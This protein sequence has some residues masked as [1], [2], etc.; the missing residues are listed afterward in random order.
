MGQDDAGCWKKLGLGEEIDIKY[1]DTFTEIEGGETF[2]ECCSSE[3]SQ[4]IIEGFWKTKFGT[5]LCHDRGTSTSPD[6]HSDFTDR[7]AC[8]GRLLNQTT[9]SKE[10]S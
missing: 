6:I 5:I 8:T 3:R 1:Q 10:K 7:G 9:I 2:D 4:K